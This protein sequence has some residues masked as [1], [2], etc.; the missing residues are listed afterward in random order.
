MRIGQAI[1]AV[2][3]IAAT[4][5]VVFVAGC[6]GSTV[7]IGGSTPEAVKTAK[8]A[9][10]VI[11]KA[12]NVDV[13]TIFCTTIIG[14]EYRCLIETPS[15]EL[16]CS[17]K[18][19]PSDRQVTTPYCLPPPTA[20]QRQ[21]ER[22][23]LVAQAFQILVARSNFAHLI[24]VAG[25]AQCMTGFKMDGDLQTDD[26]VVEL[27]DSSQEIVEYDVAATGAITGDA[28][29][30][31]APWAI[32][33]YSA[34][35]ADE[36]G[37]HLTGPTYDVSLTESVPESAAAPAPA[38]VAPP[39]DATLIMQTANAYLRTVAECFSNLTIQFSGSNRD[40]AAVHAIAVSPKP[41]ACPGFPSETIWLDKTAAWNVFAFGTGLD[42]P[43]P[44]PADISS[45]PADE[46]GVSSQ[47]AGVPTP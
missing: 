18:R 31:V 11:G 34:C 4:A 20:A 6:G 38:V 10:P 43:T 40:W 27:E 28:G 37:A 41:A 15:T 21:Q 32:N 44:V 26:V 5:I 22:A 16:A 45:C 1:L 14:V 7:S 25:S 39:D 13:R 30:G 24:S 46:S 3:A 17:T 42:C 2:A 47:G 23:A 9:L 33:P 19:A 36:S 35:T 12:E 8:L 29:R